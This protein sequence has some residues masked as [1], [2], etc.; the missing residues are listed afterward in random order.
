[1]GDNL[2]K[3]AAFSIRSDKQLEGIAQRL[4]LP[5]RQDANESSVPLP[6]LYASRSL[7]IGHQR[8]D[9]CEQFAENR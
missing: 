8:L 2:F 4:F 9:L 3:Q 5:A 6:D 1:M 7:N